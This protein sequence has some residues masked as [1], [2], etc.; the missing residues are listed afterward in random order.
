VI[1]ALQPEERSF[2]LAA[3]ARRHDP[4][5]YL[6]ALLAPADRRD[7]VLGLL[8]FHHEL[9]KVPDAVSQ[10][11]AGMIR[12]QWW[13]DAV[14]EIGQDREPRRHPVVLALADALRAGRVEAGALQALIDARERALDAVAA[15]DLPGL[16]VYVAQTAGALQAMTYRALGGSGAAEAEAARA[17]GTGFGLVGVVRAV[18]HEARA[19]R[20]P[21]PPDLLRSASVATEEIAAARMSERLAGAIAAVLDRAEA[22]VAAGRK[23]AGRPRR[24]LMA[25]FLPAALAAAQARRIRS[26]GYDPFRA[27]ELARPAGA[28]LA[29]LTRAMLRRP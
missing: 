7:T 21:L 19:R 11:M 28:P 13:R 6:C 16:E 25:A 10:P 29:L 17:I 5:R 14:E 27:A 12:Y 1:P 15:E 2:Y 9:A 18:A 3:E 4:D 26:L 20:Q 8:L 22:L 23:L 24:G